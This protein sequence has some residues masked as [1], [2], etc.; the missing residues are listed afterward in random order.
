MKLLNKLSTTLTLGSAFLVTNPIVSNLVFAEDSADAATEKGDFSIDADG[1]L[2]M[3]DYLKIPEDVDKG[4]GITKAFNDIMDKLDVA[5]AGFTGILTI[6][7]VG[8]FAWKA[9][10]L[11]KA[12]D[13]PND[14]Q[15]CITGMIWFAIGAAIFGSITMFM[16]LFYNFLN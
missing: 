10:Q 3:P 6:I 16:G 9:F 14:R 2:A 13:N 8:L 7:M 1:N 5:I 15:K 4:N 11:A 12:S